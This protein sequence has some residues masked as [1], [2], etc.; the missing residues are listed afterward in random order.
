MPN[1]L[2]DEALQVIRKRQVWEQRQRLWYTMRH[3]GVGRRNKPYV[4]ANDLHWNLIDSQIGKAKPFYFAQAFSNEK[5]A[6][7]LSLSPEM[8]TAEEAAA[9]WFDYQLKQRTEFESE[10]LSNIDIMLLSGRGVVKTFWNPFKK[11]LEFRAIEPMF[12]IVPDTANDFDDADFFVEIQQISVA[13]YKRDIRYNQDPD[14]IKLITGGQGNEL[15]AYQDEILRREGITYTANQGMIILWNEWVLQ[16]DGQREVSTYSPTNPD[17]EIRKK[18]KCIYKFQ[19]EPIC[20]YVSFPAEVKDKGWYSPRGISE[21]IAPQ[22]TYLTKLWN[23]RADY[24][25]FVSKPLFTTDGT[26]QV[27]TIS[28]EFKPGSVLAGIQPVTM[29][30]VPFNVKEEMDVTM[31]IA[32]DSIAAPDASLPD[33]K[34]S[35]K[36]NP[37]ATQVN[38]QAQLAGSQ[39]D[40]NGRIFRKRLGKLYVTSW[41]IMLFHKAQDAAYYSAG[42]RQVLPEQAKHD[43]YL[44]APDG[45]AD[46]WNRQAKVQKAVSNWQLFA[47]NPIIDQEQLAKEVFRAQDARTADKMVIPQNQK[48]ADEAK[49][50]ALNCLL[51][52]QGYPVQAM[53]YEDHQTRL[54]VLFGKMQQMQ[55]MRVPPNP[56]AIQRFQQLIAQ[57][58]TLL[59]QSNPAMAKQIMQAVEQVDPMMQQQAQAPGITAPGQTTQQTPQIG[60]A[61][62]AA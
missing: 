4:G 16:S 45:S 10:L 25:D 6:Q 48:K 61:S 34:E 46:L 58:V 35:Q 55:M 28:Q 3:H 12:M 21:R 9:D 49:Q 40:M 31:G 15:T 56:L 57:R 7:F 41:A 30:Q 23:S 51:L 18:F 11:R 59:Q 13:A 22:E 24:L 26:S 53:P 47:G 36:G 37:T 38:Y 17:L 54:Q 52:M 32:Q 14:L 2:Y 1:E 39:I 60:P 42:S 50:E 33:Q 5:L 29:P 44:I 8:Q 62:Q 19:D 43:N 20:P 27:N